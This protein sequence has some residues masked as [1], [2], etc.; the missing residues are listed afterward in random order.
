MSEQLPASDSVQMAKK[1]KSIT[2][3]FIPYWFLIFH[4]QVISISF[5]LYIK[6]TEGI[7]LVLMEEV[8][9]NACV[10]RRNGLILSWSVT[11]PRGACSAKG[12][13]EMLHQPLSKQLP[14]KVCAAG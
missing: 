8:A 3:S 13:R 9:F 10:Y 2:S 11:H 1:V 12:R 14:S 6:P 5:Q 4:L 7:K